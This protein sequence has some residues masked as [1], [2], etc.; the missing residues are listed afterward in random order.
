MKPTRPLAAALLLLVSAFACLTAWAASFTPGNIAVY[1]VGDGSTGLVN[2]GSLVFVDEFTPAGALVQTIALPSVVSG[3]NFPLI[4]S[5]TATSEGLMTRSADGRYLILTG[6]G[7][8]P[9]VSGLAGTTAAA[10]P[11]V[12]GR[13]DWNGNVD[14]STGL[15]DYASGN[16]PRGA[17]S[18]NGVNVWVT[19]GAG[20]IRYAL[21]GPDTTASTQLSTTV[22]NLRGVSIFDGQ[23]YISTSS[24]S[25]VRIGA[26]GT[27]LP[28]ASGQTITNL[29][30]I[31]P[32]SGSPYGFFFAD[33]NA[34]VPGV[35]TLY[36]ASDDAGAVTKYSLIG[37][38][39][40]SNGVVGVSADAYRGLTGI[41][42]GGVVTLYAT[43]KGGSA[44][45]GGGELVSIADS[46]GHGGTFSASAT[47]LATAAAN[48]AF[49]GVALA[50][51]S[52][53][54]QVNLGVSTHSA[55]EAAQTVVT[56]TL[57]A[58]G[59]VTGPQSVSLSVSGVNI[60][61]SDYNLSS[62][63]ITI[64][65]GAS[66][67]SVT[68]TVVDDTEAEG[69]E[70]ALLTISAPSPGIV[71]G[72]T[73]SQT[74]AIDDNEAQ[75]VSLSVNPVSTSE[76]GAAVTVTA[77]ASGPV[78]GAQ[79]VNVVVSGAGITAA[80]YNLSSV[81]I[82]IPDGMSSG[83]V[84]FTALADGATEGTEVATLTLSAPSSGLVLRPPL[85]R[86]VTIL[87]GDTSNTPPTISCAVAA[88]GGAISDPLQPSFTCTVN[89]AETA[90]GSLSVSGA[91]SNASVVPNANIGTS[92]ASGTVT[93]NVDPV[94]VG[95]ATLTFT[96][97]DGLASSQATVQYAASAASSTPSTTRF[98][99]GTSDGSAGVAID[100]AYMFVAN[101]EEETIRLYPRAGSG[102]PLASFDI[103]P[104]LGLTDGTREVDIEAAAKVGSR[105]YWLGSHSNSSSG[106]IR[107]NRYRVFAT[108]MGGSGAASTL[109]YAGR[110]DHLR[111]DLIGWDSSNA[112]GLGA[113]YFG[114]A[115]SAA[116]GVIP[117]APDGSGFNLEGLVMAPDNT[118]AY[119]AFRA[120]ISPAS[121]RTKALIVPVQNFAALAVSGGAAGSATFGAPILLDLGGRGIREI[122]KNASNQYVIIA[123]SPTATGA[124]PQ[125]F[126]FYT[127]DGNPA[128]AVVKRAADFAAFNTDG[129]FE[130]IVE[131][132]DPLT[133]ASLLQVLVDNGDTVWYNDSTISKEL[134]EPR[135]RKFRSEVV[136][137]GAPRVRIYEI[138]GARHVSPL[139]Q[140]AVSN[141]PG[142][143][144]QVS[145][146]GFY[147]QDEFGDGD[148]ATSDGIFV[149]TSS[150]PTVAAGNR[151]E[152]SGTVFEYRPGC[153]TGTNNLSCVGTSTDANSQRLTLTEI[154]TP[155]VTVTGTATIPAPVILGTGGRALPTTHVAPNCPFVGTN[156]ET[157]GACPYE[158]TGL[159]A[160]AID[161][162]E[163]LEGMRVQVN[164]PVAV[165]G[166][167][168]F[169]QFWVLADN[170]A[171]STGRNTR[172]GITI[173]D[174][175]LNPE[176]IYF[177]LTGSGT[178][179]NLS[180]LKVGAR[181]TGAFTGVVNYTFGDYTVDLPVG[182]VMPTPL[183]G[184]ND[185]PQEATALV[186]TATQLTLGSF[187]VENLGG[188][189]SQSKYNQLA[190]QIVNRMHSPDILG[191]MEVQ[192]NNGEDG[193]CPRTPGIVDATTTLNRLVTAITTAGGPSYQ[194]TEID[195]QDCTDGGAPTGNIRVA[196]FYNPARVG[197]TESNKGGTTDANAI[198]NIGGQPRLT[199]NPGRIDPTNAAFTT[200][201]KPIAAE[202]TFNGQRLI[203]IANHWN[204]KGG[205]YPEHGRF[206]PPV[207]V[208]ETQRLQIA[209][210][211]KSFVQSAFNIDPNAK[212]VVLGDLND[213]QFSPAVT[214]FKA[215]TPPMVDLVDALPAN[216]RYSYNFR[217][218]SQVLDHILVSPGIA[219]GA[220]YDAVH[221][222]AEYRIQV[223]D[224][225]PEVARLSLVARDSLAR[226]DFDAS[227]KGDLLWHHTDGRSAIWLM[228]GLAI[229]GSADIFGA[230]TA[231]Q[232]AHIAD[233]SADG[234]SDLVWQNPD[235]RITLYVM[236]GTTA[237]RKTQIM[238]AGSGW[239]VVQAGDMDANG[240]ADL[241]FRHTDGTIAA[242]LLDGEN[243]S[244]SATLL[245]GGDGWT[246]GK[247]ADFDGDGKKDLLF[248][249]PDGRAAIWTM[250]GLTPT[251]QVQIL[252]AG[253][254]WSITHTA[255]LDGD[256]RADLVFEHTDGTIAAWLL[257]GTSVSSSASLLGAGT[258][259]HVTHTGDFDGD[260]K[261]DLL[262]TH[263]DG[264]AAIWT[265]NGLVPAVQTQILNA[266]SGWSVTR[267]ADLNGDGKSDIVWTHTDGRV[268]VWL[269]NGTSMS[270]GAEILGAGTGW[271][272]SPVSQ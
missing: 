70:T 177:N 45:A 246:V 116:S 48:T 134:P 154:T 145:T 208:S 189:E 262:F 118:T 91:S 266:G 126:A 39:W 185:L 94:G 228:N 263:E 35:D 85:S 102:M 68:F 8:T 231:W 2:T 13:I 218:N 251:Q 52:G 22:T 210:V 71:L 149:F 95:Y 139:H 24:G 78:Q 265:M 87:D 120:P 20:G 60:N 167:V 55:S 248:T 240:Q 152:V 158:P 146:D 159:G 67:G 135:F 104:M 224:H 10:V 192:D 186:G 211:V 27:G 93:V 214:S 225:D 142:I 108:D 162:W 77:N 226:G 31:S 195:P 28:T 213:F 64:P 239:S 256:G 32:S 193:T 160:N 227:G 54:R 44:A 109:T 250:D 7:A 170:G 237:T 207:L 73:T 132:P 230:G 173:S 191:L 175:D 249:N 212:I 75:G 119:L 136:A 83:S 216:E 217:G 184:S 50:P 156:I 234:K 153:T 271:S 51:E 26:V 41:V 131:V 272:V 17:A 165:S 61:P 40:T 166:F 6:Y 264:R 204:S 43:R 182:F 268:A 124:P 69:P 176:R 269:M 49:R 233:V 161:F 16:N 254:G 127:W 255:D 209:A 103:K 100:G 137:L 129:S 229:A 259:W 14:T 219:G 183:G 180:D 141:V 241:V 37:G 56:V 243:V 206:Q 92:N 147:M 150:P 128:S 114:L 99:Y 76:G 106:S 30:G 198:V 202:F 188:N 58:D 88:I 252:N 34:G 232:V 121:A 270:S 115:A 261:T 38:T 1:R 19:G 253:S 187:N 46:S 220:E 181:W 157:V 11:R 105:I 36:V 242:W 81:T 101:D 59:P 63:T 42:S 111:T 66:S 96:V 86:D 23:L 125:D 4:S 197:F 221:A 79:S 90:P 194:Y 257:S 98:H 174:G 151:V 235:G 9:P 172:G 222:N 199:R 82:T 74:I 178:A 33:L 5:G 97:S 260:G 130:G 110:Y 164:D 201:R 169:E 144:T 223:S 168:T 15:N 140:Q 258:G 29:P 80:D 247:M 155:T 200:S 179:A 107:V 245:A 47:V 57:T 12:V 267:V 133:S 163:S 18:D 171:N 138:Q 236:D 25:A 62:S 205:D 196:F 122:A 244:G 89:D 148:D 215:T 238:N 72:P 84:T 3:D 190:D 53:Q 143:V 21:I 117:E 113:N 123:G 65:G 112:H 203:V